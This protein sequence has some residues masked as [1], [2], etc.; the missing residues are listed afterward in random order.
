MS[1]LAE[2]STN[3]RDL[4]RDAAALQAAVAELVRVYQFR[5]RDRICC[6][7]ISVTQCYALE[8]LVQHA[9][10]RLRALANQLFGTADVVGRRITMGMAP[11][12]P[13][14]EI[15]GVVADAKYTTL[16]RD[17]P[18]T[19]YFPYQQGSLN[20][21][22]YEVRTAGDPLHQVEHG[23]DLHRDRLAKRLA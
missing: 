5:D 6:H 14:L 13:E 15:V 10:M 4:Q 23:R 8:T 3:T 12:A 2:R 1:Q 11:K 16:K 18:P 19:A 9:P 7:D 22:T 20:R 21:A 17:A